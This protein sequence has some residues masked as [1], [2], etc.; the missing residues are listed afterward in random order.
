MQTIVE[1]SFGLLMKMSKKI[2]LAL[3]FLLIF[4]LLFP[5]QAKYIINSTLLLLSSILPESVQSFLTRITT[6]YILNFFST[7]LILF[8]ISLIWEILFKTSQNAGPINLELNILFE[9]NST[10]LIALIIYN[11][12]S[13]S[14]ISFYTITDAI[15]PSGLYVLFLAVAFAIFIFIFSF[16]YLFFFWAILMNIWSIPNVILRILLLILFLFFITKLGE[17][18]SKEALQNMI[19]NTLEITQPYLFSIILFS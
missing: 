15:K 19:D 13:D 14:P 1:K 8:L 3:L 12:V 18:I 9:L 6:E 5:V 4:T 7:T 10:G 2:P 16:V 17:Y 11:K